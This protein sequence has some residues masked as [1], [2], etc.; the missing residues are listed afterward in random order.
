MDAEDFGGWV[1][2]RV[3]NLVGECCALRVEPG[4]NYGLW[5]WDVF[6]DFVVH[7]DLVSFEACWDRDFIV[8]LFGLEHDY[9]RA[10]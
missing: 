4:T 6:I 10:S 5:A 1:T 8:I 7:D 9:I 2:L 3:W